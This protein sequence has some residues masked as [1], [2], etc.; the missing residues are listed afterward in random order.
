MRIVVLYNFSVVSYFKLQSLLCV[1]FLYSLPLFNNSQIESIRKI[2]HQWV[3]FLCKE[4]SGLGKIFAIEG[5]CPCVSWGPFGKMTPEWRS[6]VWTQQC[7]LSLGFHD[8]LYLMWQISHFYS[9]HKIIKWPVSS[10]ELCHV[11]V[12]QNIL[13]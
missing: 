3:T 11:N 10:Q 13:A 5:H 7:D 8:S 6:S 9:T 1:W 12:L 2:I 4:S